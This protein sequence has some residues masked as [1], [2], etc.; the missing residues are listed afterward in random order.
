MRR[1]AIR[2]VTARTALGVTAALG[3]TWAAFA[4][5]FNLSSATSLHLLL[6]TTIALRWGLLEASIVSLLSV[7]CLD[8]FFTD[9]VFAFDMR[10]SRDWVALLTFEGVA[11]LA[12]RLSNQ[13]RSHAAEAERSRSQVQKLYEL[14]QHILLLDRQKPVDQQLATLIQTTF[15]MRGVAL[16]NANELQL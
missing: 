9:P 4:F 12:S 7:L 8:Y 15:G 3:I 11:L 6:V 13:V 14:S 1:Q 16:W 10:D 2:E 5:H